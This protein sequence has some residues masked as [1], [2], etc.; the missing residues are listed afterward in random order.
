[1]LHVTFLQEREKEMLP[2]D[3]LFTEL[4]KLLDENTVDALRTEYVRRN[5][6]YKRYTGLPYAAYLLD[7]A[8]KHGIS[9]TGRQAAQIA[10]VSH[11]LIYNTLKRRNTTM[12]DLYAERAYNAIDEKIAIDAIL[13]INS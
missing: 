5:V 10:Q 4:Q 13:S 6:F 7:V 1:M 12:E 8:R 11:S 9:C 2:I 3:W